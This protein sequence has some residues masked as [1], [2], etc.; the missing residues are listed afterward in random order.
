[1]QRG[2]TLP[3]L[4]AIAVVTAVTIAPSVQGTKPGSDGLVAYARYR[5]VSSPLRKEI[6]VA[7][8]DGATARRVD[9]VGPNVEDDNPDWSPDGKSLAFQRCPSQYRGVCA[10]YS[11]RAD[12]SGLDRLTP[13]CPRG[14][15]LPKCVDDTMPAYSPDGKH[16]A[17]SRASGP[18][19]N[20]RPRSVALMVGDVQ[21]RHLRRVAW[22]G[23]YRGAPTGPAWSPDGRR[24]V[25]ENQV[26]HGRALYIV[27]ADG[28]GL[29][30][31][32]PPGIKGTDQADW[33]PDGTA[34]LFRGGPGS[35]IGDEAGNLYTIRPDGSGLRQLTH[36]PNLL[37][38]VRNGSYSPDGQS[39]VFATTYEGTKG[40]AAHWPDLFVMRTDG[41]D[42]R[43][44][45][46]TINWEDG[47][48][49]GPKS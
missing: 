18:F 41:T 43:P 46:R 2:L 38:M 15:N 25:F 34:I 14:Q 10:V 3:L 47:P 7:S 39:I 21:L 24:L 44:M 33:S 23:Q 37:G 30:R 22:F 32:T 19:R 17:V 20:G 9:T 42:L 29:R 12:G 48:D 45:T 27:N 4:G 40:P 49:W 13:S 1:M 5:F 8:E 28:T 35:D 16:L 26:D 31:L 36:F 6:W 11:I